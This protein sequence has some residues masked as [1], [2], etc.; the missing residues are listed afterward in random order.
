MLP[1]GFYYNKPAYQ[2]E[3][4]T[5]PTQTESNKQ[6]TYGQKL[7]RQGWLAGSLSLLHTLF[8]VIFNECSDSI[9]LKYLQ[10]PDEFLVIALLSWLIFLNSR[11]GAVLMVA[12]FASHKLILLLSGRYHSVSISI[13]DLVL[14]YYYIA[15]AKGTFL[16]HKYK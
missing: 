4:K 7:I 15:A 5:I 9:D 13:I 14:L 12:Y 3:C 6:K 8:A 11:I 2:L 1:N 10:T 16:L